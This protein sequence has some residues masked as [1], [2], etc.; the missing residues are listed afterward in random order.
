MP[1]LK[2]CLIAIAATLLL[3][4]ICAAALS[5]SSYLVQGSVMISIGRQIFYVGGLTLY[6]FQWEQ[7]PVSLLQISFI[8]MKTL[9]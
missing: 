2:L 7:R 8:Q 1:V 5:F 4:S 3:R 9:P 6:A